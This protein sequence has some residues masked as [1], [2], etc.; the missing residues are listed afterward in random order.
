MKVLDPGST[1]REG[2]FANAQNSG[3]VP[4]RI[5]AIYN[6]V[7]EGT[8]LTETQRQD[9]LT[10]AG[11]LFNAEAERQI[12][13]NERFK[14]RGINAGVPELL[15]GPILPRAE[16]VEILNRPDL[17]DLPEPRVN[18]GVVSPVTDDEEAKGEI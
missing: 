12:E 16:L 7:V 3:S 1:V 13:R 4:Q 5:R 2:E 17:S 18:G 9:F 6:S 14:Q 11:D 15:I 10:R 8:R